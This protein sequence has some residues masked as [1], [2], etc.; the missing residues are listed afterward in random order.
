MK[1]GL[2][3]F[4]LKMIALV[5]MITDHVYSYLNGPVHGYQAEALW[6]QWIPLLTRFV[7]PL[8]LYLMIE[9]FYHTRS[10]RKYLTR[11]FVT[12]LIMWCGNV[13]INFLFHNVN[14][15]TGKYSF[16]SL[17]SGHNIFLTLAVLFVFIHCLENIK[18]HEKTIL[19]C[20]LAFI[21]AVL[22][23]VLEGGFYLLPVT[24]IVW[25]FR[26]KKSLQCA[27]IAVWSIALLL[28][29]LISFYS[30][31]TGTTLYS[32]LCFDNEWAMFPVILFILLY[33]GERGR[34]T[35][36][37]K[38]MFYIIYPVHLWI[39]MIIRYCITL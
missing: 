20:F 39:L 22:S 30:G 18:Q 11:L 9:G 5:F 37:S 23:I 12:A 6:P 3:V 33:N 32:Y 28:H 7:S 4:K 26:N 34:N 19:N 24:L 10:R 31:N 16:S 21:M 25:L 15:S 35:A 29:T 27:G 38:Y 36:F 1:R 2:D 14:P 8:F 13:M 17:I